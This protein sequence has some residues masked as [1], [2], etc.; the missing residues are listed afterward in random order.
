MNT[1]TIRE[2]AN[3]YLLIV[4]DHS[5]ERGMYPDGRNSFV[6]KDAYEM[7]TFIAQRR[8]ARYTSCIMIVR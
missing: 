1:F 8:A 2:V 6:F 4:N 7:A 5:L 3:G